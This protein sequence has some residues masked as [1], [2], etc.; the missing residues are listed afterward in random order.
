MNRTR[1]L[2]RTAYGRLLACLFLVILLAGCE[3][4]PAPAAAT[5]TPAPTAK[6]AATATPA[7]SSV[8]APAPAVVAASEPLADS[9]TAPPARIRIPEIGMDVAVQPMGW[10]VTEVAGQRTTVWVLPDAAAGWHPNSGRAGGA[11]NVVISGHQLLGDAPFAPIALGEVAVGQEILLTDSQGQV[12]V[13]QVSEVSDPLVIEE[14][15]SKEMKLG[16]EIAAQKGDPRLTLI[17]GWPDF[18]S[19]HRVVVTA[20]F[21]GVQP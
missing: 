18:S 7:A 2:W 14:D 11:G 16:E 17:S 10:R 6:P 4:M 13:Y 20:L 1:S 3:P 21:V 5:S 15:P 19:T 9:E 8:A 12:F